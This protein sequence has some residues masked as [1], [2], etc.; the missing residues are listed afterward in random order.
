MFRGYSDIF[1]KPFRFEEIPGGSLTEVYS[2]TGEL[3]ADYQLKWIGYYHSNTYEIDTP[4]EKNPLILGNVY[5]RKQ[6]WLLEIF[7]T[8]ET[9][10]FDSK[11]NLL[12]AL[13]K[14]AK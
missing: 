1:V 13:D 3:V 4:V 2:D 5:Y 12:V 11:E 10:W 8:K 6:L 7:I 14:Y 9:R